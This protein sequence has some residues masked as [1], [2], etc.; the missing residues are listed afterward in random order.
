MSS[1]GDPGYGTHPLP[2]PPP[3][4]GE[5]NSLRSR[6]N[7][8][9]PSRG[10]AGVG[11]ADA[12]GSRE[13]V[14]AAAV[15]VLV[16]VG[17]PWLNPGYR[18]LSVAISTGTV[19]IT[20]YGL[21]LLFGQAG[22]MSVG[23]AALM[24]V[25][26]YT[27][28]ILSM[29]LGMGLWSALPFSMFMAALAAALIGLPALRVSGHHFV[30]ITYAFCTL[31][32]IVLTNGGSFTGGATGLDV[33]PVGTVLGINM[34]RLRNY[35]LLV[36]AALLASMLATYLISAS[37]YGRTLRSIR[38]NEPLARAVGINTGLHKVGAFMM[39]GA[40]AGAAG[41]FQAYYLRH[42]SPTLYGGLPS[43]Y[44]AMSVMLGGAR[45]LYG[46]LG[47]AIIV[48]FLPEILNIDPVDSRIAYGAGLVAVILLLPRGMVDG[49]IGLYRW[50]A[51]QRA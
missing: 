28:A 37:G 23:H 1:N 38:E 3:Q 31:L 35:Y 17:V 9:P 20:L 18:F 36:I 44:I 48:N 2:G 19:A 40:F 50:A 30:I 29:R 7:L 33:E 16:L 42:I 14:V 22:I 32:A 39:S 43:L 46:P 45:T 41:I 51:R 10:R 49:L 24:G 34:D 47:G 8:P 12:R 27:A 4:A 25:G 5:G 11:A 21:A 26:A 6:Q 15:L 13:T